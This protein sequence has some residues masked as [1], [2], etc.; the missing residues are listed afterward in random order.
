M[1]SVQCAVRS[2]HLNINEV[3]FH[4]VS[5]STSFFPC[6]YH[7]TFVPHSPSST[8]YDYQKDRRANSG[9]VPQ[10]NDLSEIGQHCTEKYFHFFPP[11]K[12]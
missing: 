12:Y 1:E 5:P 11:L 4:R 7:S 6:P 3:N 8:R 9:N 2:W 10:D